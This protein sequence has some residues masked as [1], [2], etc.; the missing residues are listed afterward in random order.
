MVYYY[1]NI[2]YEMLQDARSKEYTIYGIYGWGCG[3]LLTIIC[4][5]MNHFLTGEMISSLKPNFGS[6]C[7]GLMS[8]YKLNK[9]ITICLSFTNN[10]LFFYRQ[11]CIENIFFCSNMLYNCHVIIYIH[12][13]WNEEKKAQKTCTILY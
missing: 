1:S 4:F 7:C 12:I 6:D 2:K 10:Y 11:K 3:I 9:F 5:I 8:K 13:N